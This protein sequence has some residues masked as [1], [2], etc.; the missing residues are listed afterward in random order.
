MASQ[1]A[2]DSNVRKSLE[3]KIIKF[4][5][6]KSSDGTQRYSDFKGLKI[7]MVDEDSGDYKG[8]K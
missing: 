7:Y 5:R 3:A 4:W 1:T 8:N 6:T 2:I